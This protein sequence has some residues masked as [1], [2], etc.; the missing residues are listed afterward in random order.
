M[1]KQPIAERVTE[2]VRHNFSEAEIN[3]MAKDIS[4]KIDEAE[5]IK[6]EQG[7]VAAKYK[8]LEKEKAVEI[9]N[10]SRAIR[11]GFDMRREPCFMIRD[12]KGGLVYYYLCMDLDGQIDPAKY[13][14]P[15]KLIDH[16]SKD[17]TFDPIKTRTLRENERQLSVVDD[18]TENKEAEVDTPEEKKVTAKKSGR[19][20]K[21]VEVN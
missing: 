7:S 5:N 8:S 1:K 21:N 19:K 20:S 4:V 13:D 15:E 6:K 3:Q 16:L 17:E 9:Q 11:D 2:M 14:K 10:L 18:P 12:F